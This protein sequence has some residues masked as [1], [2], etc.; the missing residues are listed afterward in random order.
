MS[1]HKQ[2]RP[3]SSA[4]A[5]RDSSSRYHFIARSMF[6][7]DKIPMFYFLQTLKVRE[8]RHEEYCLRYQHLRKAPCD[9][10]ILRMHIESFSNRGYGLVT[11]QQAH[12]TQAVVIKVVIQT[13]LSTRRHK[14]EDK[15]RYARA[16][17]SSASVQLPPRMERWSEPFVNEEVDKY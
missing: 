6:S 10:F 5:T 12:V 4:C 9:I 17:E 11:T 8:L 16:T 13:N 14:S 15:A 3:S 2:T 1:K 7:L